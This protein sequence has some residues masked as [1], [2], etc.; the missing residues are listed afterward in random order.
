MVIALLAFA[1]GAGAEDFVVV[2]PISGMV[3]DGLVVL[4]ER[5]VEEAEGAKALIFEVD[6]PGGLVDAAIR[7]TKSIGEAPCPTIA[8]IKG[9]G[10]ISAGALISFSCQDIIMEPDSNIGAATPVIASPEG[11][12]PTGE[13]EVSYMRSK[14]RSLAETNGHNPSIA[15]AMVDKDIELWAFENA[16]GKLQIQGK[17]GQS[18]QSDAAPERAV[19]KEIPVPAELEPVKEIVDKVIKSKSAVP[20]EDVDEGTE[21]EA[22]PAKSPQRPARIPEDAELILP[23]GKLLTLTPQEAVKYGLIPQ[24]VQ[25]L[26]EALEIY[27]YAGAEVRRLEMTWA[28][29]TYRFLTNPMVAGIL[30]LLAIGGIYLEIKTPGFGLPGI[31]GVTCLC[32][33][34]G[35]NLILGIA[36]WLDILLVLLGIVFIIVELFLIPGF[37]IIGVAGILMLLTGIYLALTGVTIPE[38]SWEYDRITDAAKSMGLAFALLVAFVAVMWKLLPHTPVYGTLVLTAQQ[39]ADKGWTVQT[40]AE[41]TLAVGLKGVATSML[42]PAGRGAFEGTTYQV[43]SRGEYIAPGTPI[44]IVQ[45]DG[46]RYVVDKLEE[47]V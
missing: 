44:V 39:N 19:K 34:L 12:L 37:G 17:Y 8:Y 6:T 22:A 7:I 31:I 28:E 13:K 41:Q 29:K 23:A 47:T 10:A 1:S 11:N 46:N 43:V 14:M 33:L 20:D 9:M 36:D 4:V 15:E 24:T 3:D 26:E 40:A 25:N 27:G 2:C 38:F 5:A 21:K 18:G 30:L 32:L 35:A 42:R 16:D 45:V